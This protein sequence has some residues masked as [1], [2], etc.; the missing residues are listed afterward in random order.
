MMIRSALGL[1]MLGGLVAVASAKPRGNVPVEEANTLTHGMAQM[2]LRVGETTQMEVLDAFGG[3]N[4]TTLDAEGREVWV[5]DRHATVTMDKNS[6]F[7]I[8]ML[9]AAATGNVAG[10]TGLGFSSKKSKASQSSRS[11]VL[12]IKFASDKKVVD[13]KSRSSS[14]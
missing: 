11:M 12:V 2:T 10:G 7:S 3:P 1:L 9:V 8:G 4:I 5:Y 13:F 14:Y 6:G